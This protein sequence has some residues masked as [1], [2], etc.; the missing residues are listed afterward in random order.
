MRT[1]VVDTDMALASGAHGDWGESGE[2][3]PARRLS[4]KTQRSEGAC[5]TEELCVV[6]DRA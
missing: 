2:R 4:S 5:V 3:I 1:K 6:P